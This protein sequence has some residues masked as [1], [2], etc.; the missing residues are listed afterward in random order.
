VSLLYCDSSALVKLVREEAESDALRTFIADC[1]QGPR[2][3][4]ASSALSHT[5]V[6]R[7]VSRS[8]HPLVAEAKTLLAGIT[9]I[10]ITP[11]V[12]ERAGLLEPAGLRS[13]DAIHLA[14][15]LPESAGLI[16]VVTY[17]VRMSQAAREVGLS[18]A[19]PGV[20]E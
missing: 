5:E 2:L 19:S 12:L 20:A 13:L 14:S 11:E 7:T 18:V 6:L 3:T 1:D 16:A 8:S 4:I 15:V 10:D 9:L 17:D